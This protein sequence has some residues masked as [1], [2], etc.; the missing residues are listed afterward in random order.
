MLALGYYG[1]GDKEHSA[2][3][4]NELQQMDINHYG[5]QAFLSLM[6]SNF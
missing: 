3:Y 2:R 5:I 6:K 4:L 1:L